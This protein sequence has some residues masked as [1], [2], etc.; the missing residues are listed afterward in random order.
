VIS[1]TTNHLGYA[2]CYLRKTLDLSDDGTVVM[3]GHFGFI[4]NN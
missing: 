2:E 1:I 3:L 4:T